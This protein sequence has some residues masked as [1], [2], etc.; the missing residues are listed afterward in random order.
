[1]INRRFKEVKNLEKQIADFQPILSMLS[2]MYGVDNVDSLK[3]AIEND[4]TIW[5]NK[6]YEAGMDVEQFKKLQRLEIANRDLQAQRDQQ[7][8]NDNV[9]RQMQAWQEQAELTQQ[10]YPD[11]DLEVEKANPKF[12][13][14][15]MAH[16]DVKTAYETV[17]H[18]ELLRD[19]MNFQEQRTAKAVTDNIRAK[20]TRPLENG[21]SQQGAFIVKNDVNALSKEDRAEIA[22]RVAR[23][24][25]IS[26]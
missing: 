10:F 2:Q 5:E 26:F 8:F 7:I 14:L 3:Q 12:R 21:T 4:N 23:G 20:G 6:A 22:R 9:N 17:H 24:E 25:V 16:V 11:F 19:A 18:E 13:D 15:L 1:M